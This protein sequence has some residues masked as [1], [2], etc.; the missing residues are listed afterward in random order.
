MAIS[1]TQ[2]EW[3]DISTSWENLKKEN[4]LEVLPLKVTK[5]CL[6]ELDHLNLYANLPYYSHRYG[7]IPSYL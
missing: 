7:N 1:D 5:I 2:L 3:E 4:N 6:E